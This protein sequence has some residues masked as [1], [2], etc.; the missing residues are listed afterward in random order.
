MT[1]TALASSDWDER[2][3]ASA[4]PFLVGFWAEWCVPS[5]GLASTL[6]AVGERFG[7]AL[8]LGLVDVASQPGLAE[9]CDIQGLPTLMLLREGR[10]ALRRIGLLTSEDLVALLEARL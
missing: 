2:V 1:V 6:E 4:A 8:R 10:E 5:R 7:D 9:R 3:L